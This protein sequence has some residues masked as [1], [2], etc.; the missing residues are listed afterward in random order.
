MGVIN[1]FVEPPIQLSAELSFGYLLGTLAAFITYVFDRTEKL[2]SQQERLLHQPARGVEVFHSS[3]EFLQKLIDI[4]V[5]ATS[6]STLNLS[7]ARGEHPELDRYF[8]EVHNYIKSKKATLK[9]FRSIASVDTPQ[10]SLWLVQR[11]AELL[12]TGRVSFAVF[13]QQ[14][15][16]PLLHP[17][18]IHITAKNDNLNVF[19]FPPVN[20]TGSMSSILISDAALARVMLGYFDL[21]WH[22]ALKINEGKNVRRPGLDRLLHLY[23]D[24]ESNFHYQSLRRGLTNE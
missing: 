5:G 21:L 7:P 14:E 9:S 12:S 3:D 17:L 20:L 1:L 2:M 15:L 16:R 4:T 11:S 24:I 10:K 6:V 18:S 19:I 8:T 22:D 13:D 23:P